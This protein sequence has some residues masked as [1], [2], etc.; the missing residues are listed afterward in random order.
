MS[1]IKY[2]SRCVA[3][4][5]GAFGLLAV[6]PASAS[7]WILLI[8]EGVKPSRV[9]YYAQSDLIV[10]GSGPED[11]AAA[12][13]TKDWEKALKETSIKEVHVLQV[14]ESAEAPFVTDYRVQ[15]RCNSRTLRI[16][17][18]LRLYHDDRGTKNGDL[19]D[20]RET[21]TPWQERARV[22]AC[23]S[24]RWQAALETDLKRQ[25]PPM[26]LPNLGLLFVG[27]HLEQ[28][29]DEFTWSTLWRDG[30]R[31]A[32]ATTKSK[33]E[34]DALEKSALAELDE[35]V[36]VSAD[37]MRSAKQN[38]QAS[39]AEMAFT[40][41]V[42]ATFKEKPYPEAFKQQMY[43]MLGWTS[44]QINETLGYADE[45]R[46][47][48]DAVLHIYRSGKDERNTIVVS[49]YGHLATTGK[50]RTCQLTLV[51]REGGSELG[52]RLVDY[53]MEGENC[54]RS[55]LLKGLKQY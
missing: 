11:V 5:A 26:A 16:T 3:L 43:P 34:I 41:K 37:V 35:S 23:D 36:K 45:E 49:P 39:D 28:E 1:H 17:R 47:S 6:L 20:W 8:S 44:A 22:V 2:A 55:T 46:Q 24:L 40:M 48:G 54:N 19:S 52:P 7:E 15:F 38:V 21:S 51:F 33:S 10:E 14:S 13:K 18:H 32:F 50:L 31:Q 29:I 53:E 4:T 12:F 42:G 25:G 27:E 9:A 30:T